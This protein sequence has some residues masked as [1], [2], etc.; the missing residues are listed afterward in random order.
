MRIALV[1]HVLN[2]AALLDEVAST[3][4]GATSLFLGTVRNVNEGREVTGIEYTAYAAMATAELDRIAHEAAE[5]FGTDRIVIEH[6][7][8]TLTLGEASIAIVVAHE[9]RTPAMEASRY[10]IEEIKKRVPIWKREHYADGTREWVD[11][12]RAPETVEQAR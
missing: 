9:R 5:R 10:L 7:I 6:R 11:P 8:G 2:A 4:C 12:T 1:E 3:S